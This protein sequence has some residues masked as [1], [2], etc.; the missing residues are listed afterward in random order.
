MW[1]WVIRAKR[2]ANLLPI[3][4]SVLAGFHRKQPGESR[5]T[6]ADLTGATGAQR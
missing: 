2:V 5:S 4:E 3:L 1:D 6:V